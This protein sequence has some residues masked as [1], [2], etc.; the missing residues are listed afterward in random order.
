MCRCKSIMI[1]VF[2]DCPR[3]LSRERRNF[4]NGQFYRENLYP[5]INPIISISSILQ[6]DFASG[7]ISKA[8]ILIQSKRIKNIYIV[9]VSIS[10]PLKMHTYIF[11]SVIYNYNYNQ[12]RLITISTSF[13]HAVNRNIR[14]E[15]LI[16]MRRMH[17][18]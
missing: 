14:T 10:M 16:K 5:I 13:N 1:S 11:I 17:L 3:L 6:L 18:N 7:D 4:N 9:Y 8:F 15:S 2:I 12:S